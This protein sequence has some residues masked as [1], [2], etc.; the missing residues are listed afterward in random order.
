LFRTIDGN[1]RRHSG[2]GFFETQRQRHFNV[3]ATLWLGTRWFPFRFSA[4]EEVSE[5]VFEA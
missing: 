1:V 4:T 3:A 2:D 5:N